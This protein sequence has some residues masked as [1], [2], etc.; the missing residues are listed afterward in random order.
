MSK[1]VRLR[2]D[3]TRN[4]ERLLVEARA[5]FSAGEQAVSLEALAKAAGV[6]VGTLY[7]HFPTREALVEAVYRSELEALAAEAALLLAARP[8]LDALRLWMVR[9]A[10]FVDTK[11]AMR[12][13]L[14]IAFTTPGAVAP[15]TRAHIRSVVGRFLAAGVADGSVREGL[16]PDDVALSLAGAVLVTASSTEYAQQERLLNILTDGLKPPR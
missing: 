11:H 9:Y 6:G 16:D 15:E 12:A 2:S 4:R 10:R 13:A 7:R 5:R 14:R 3:A 8:A 1:S